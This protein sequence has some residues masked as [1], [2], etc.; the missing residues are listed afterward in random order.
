MMMQ[1][2]SRR[3]VS[4]SSAETLL[5]QVPEPCSY[6]RLVVAGTVPVSAEQE[7]MALV[8]ARVERVLV[9]AKGERILVPLETAA[10]SGQKLAVAYE[11]RAGLSRRRARKWRAQETAIAAK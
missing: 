4:R 7:E 5:G 9:L 8:S 3:L 2:G 10:W 1:C 11:T 6:P